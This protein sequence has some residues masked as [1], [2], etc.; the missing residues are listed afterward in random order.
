[1]TD[2]T[3]RL[4]FEA[5][6]RRLSRQAQALEDTGIGRS[7]VERDPH[8]YR[9]EH[10]NGDIILDRRGA[11]FVLSV[12]ERSSRGTRLAEIQ[13]DMEGRI[14]LRLSVAAARFIANVWPGLV[15]D[16]DQ[17]REAG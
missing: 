17:E 9:V 3:P 7:G 4:P 1:M 12:A 2:E 13:F 5:Q 8:H 11:Q 16:Y 15:A 6:R 10:P 14:V